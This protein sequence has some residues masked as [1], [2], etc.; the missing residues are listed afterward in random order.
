MKN[1]TITTI[2]A[3]LLGAAGA[4]AQG[5]TSNT[6]YTK[7]SGFVTHTLKSGQ[8]NLIGLTLHKPVAVSGEL[9]TVSEKTLTDTSVD[10]TTVLTAGKT[11]ILEIT[12]NPAEPSLVGTIQEVTSWAATTLTTPQDLGADGLT[13]DT[14]DGVD[15]ANGARYQLRE[16]VTLETV[17][18]TTDSVLQKGV[19]STLADIVWI[20][21]GAGEY[22]RYFLSNTNQ[23]KD[24]TTNTAAPNVP[25]IY[26]DALFVQRK[27]ADVNLVVT[28]NV[29]TINTVVA[30]SPGFNPISIIAP[31]GSTLQ[32]LGLDKSL[33]AGVI[34]TLADIV[35]VPNASG[36]YDRY[37]LHT[38]N[39]WRD[40]T[41]N[42]DVASDVVLPKGIFIQ[43][44]GVAQN[45]NITPPSGYSNL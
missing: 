18:G 22:N 16:A 29:K 8:F 44:K 42:A 7:P 4:Y 31:V 40:A 20:P 1:T 27:G 35:W 25:L 33:Q 26:V 17:F 5:G 39:V 30:L 36:S 19:I 41:T 38:T 34:S 24:A 21:D 13:G 37:Y 12:A 28:G 23:W 15:N 9:E 14:G 43:R 6:A 11:Y 32:N 2:A 45:I 10:F 3:L